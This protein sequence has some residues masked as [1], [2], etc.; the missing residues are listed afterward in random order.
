M[1]INTGK[2]TGR[3]NLRY[4]SYDDLLADVESLARKPICTLGNWSQPQIYKH[5]AMSLDSCIDGTGFALPAPMRWIMSILM[6]KKFLHG[7]LPPGYKAPAS[8]VPSEQTTLEDASLGLKRAI[9][10]VKT[11]ESRAIHPAFG[12]LST[13]EWDQFNLRH[14]EMH[15]SFLQTVEPSRT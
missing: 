5:L 9:Q 15:M 7:V 10:R 13:Q 8:F 14:A 3:R 2:V 4:R 1:S 6:K 11:N 12:R